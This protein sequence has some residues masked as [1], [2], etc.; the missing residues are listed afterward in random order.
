MY[1]MREYIPAIMFVP[2]VLVQI[3]D[4]AYQ[5]LSLYICIFRIKLK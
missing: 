3:P 5:D 2:E 4:L 1:L